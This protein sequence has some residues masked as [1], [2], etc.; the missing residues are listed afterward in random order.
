VV[1]AQTAIPRVIMIRLDRINVAMP[2]KG[3][4]LLATLK[5]AA[6]SD[7]LRLWLLVRFA[8]L[9]QRDP[10]S[11]FSDKNVSLHGRQALGDKVCVYNLVLAT[12][13][14]PVS[15]PHK[16]ARLGRLRLASTHYRWS[17]SHD[18]RLHEQPW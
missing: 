3:F 9:R 17:L 6:A 11:D 16:A 1:G 18:S 4:E 8:R 7:E 12:G 2:G 5:E 13:P 15:P 10:I 14:T